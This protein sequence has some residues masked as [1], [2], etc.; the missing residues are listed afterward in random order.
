LETDLAD[1]ARLDETASRARK[2]RGLDFPFE[3]V[4][5]SGEAIEVA[6][7]VLWMRLAMPLALDHINVYALAEG[8]S[9]TIVD[10]GLGL[11][12]TRDEWS[13]L[14]AGPLGGR[15]V[16]RVI[17]THMHPDHIG[18]AGWLCGRFDAP[19]WMTR[20]EY[21][22]ARMLLADTGT[23]APE[24]GAA[25]YR[26]AGW[27][28]AQIARYRREFGQFGRAVDPL[29]AG[30]VRMRDGDR[31][32]L[33]GRIWK[34]V[35]GEG[36]SPEHAC[37]WREEDDLVLGGD[38][39][40]PRISSNISVWPTEPDADPLGDWLSSLE[41]MKTALPAGALVLP[42]HGEPFRGV[43]A[44]LE[45]LI[46]GHLASLKRL[47]RAL[48]TPKRAVDVFSTLFARPV[49][50]GVRGMA[51]GESLAH[52]NYLHRQGRATRDRDADG[53]VWWTATSGK[54]ETA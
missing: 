2:A 8:D 5:A 35:V 26:G 46:R 48:R 32:C 6:D 41:R 17:C 15:P 12:G 30:F 39:I 28:E 29:P 7:G 49:G 40:L 3:R 25:F 33:G 24:S 51:T 53:V 50:D 43:Q 52:L 13:A 37:L 38:Q 9:W 22:T 4:P 34:V 23:P 27:D 45:A 44:R 21:V 47:E 18:L 14:L 20:L 19:L 31:L 36:H 54:R 42:S 1:G 11:S 16:T 10:T